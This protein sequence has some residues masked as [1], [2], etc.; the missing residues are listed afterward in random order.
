MFGKLVFPPGIP[1]LA[2]PA[3]N[4][5]DQ[6]ADLGQ[7]VSLPAD[8]NVTAVGRNEL[9]RMAI[10]WQRA[11]KQLP[12]TFDADAQVPV[13]YH[14]ELEPRRWRETRMVMA[15]LLGEIR[16]AV[17]EADSERAT[18]A[19]LNLAEVEEMV[20]RGVARRE[21]D[22]KWAYLRVIDFPSLLKVL[23]AQDAHRLSRGLLDLD[24]KT[25][26]LSDIERRQ[27]ARDARGGGWR[28]R[29]RQVIDELSGESDT[30]KAQFAFRYQLR[31]TIVRSWSLAA[32]VRAFWLEQGALPPSLT[33]LVPDYLQQIPANPF[34]TGPAIEYQPV[35]DRSFSLSTTPALSPSVGLPLT[36]VEFRFDFD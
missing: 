31:R 20:G 24:S 14:E 29:A 28:G 12:K 6:L 33:A 26:R 34:E 15:A 27:A 2:P 16:L 35:G 19:L 8:A 5:Y 36:P 23:A 18:D 7:L 32:A 17:F 11:L 4:A 25:E 9:D 30:S 22:S 13:N 1:A 10:H 21:F 3:P